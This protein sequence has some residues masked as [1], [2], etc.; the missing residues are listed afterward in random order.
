[1]N[2][3][4]WWK[5]FLVGVVLEVLG[6]LIVPL[7]VL[8]GYYVRVLRRTLAGDPEPPSFGQ[9]GTLLVNGLKMSV[10]TGAYSAVPILVFLGF[11]FAALDAGNGLLL[12]GRGFRALLLGLFWSLAIAAVFSYVGAAGL[13]RFAHTGKLRSAFSPTVL[14]FVFS[15]AWFIM[16]LKIGIISLG[17]A[18]V[19]VIL[20]LLSAGILGVVLAPVKVKYLGTV[21][22]RMVGKTYRRRVDV[23]SVPTG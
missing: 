10:I 21:V 6:F 17:L 9:P 16:W 20:S 22:M 15:G 7:I 14:T 12:T 4:G 3:A 1:M 8:Q 13:A 5:T 18:L 2:E 23:D 11:F 19:G